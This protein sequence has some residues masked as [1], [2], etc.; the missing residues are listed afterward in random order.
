MSDFDPYE[1]LGVPRD[2]DA[3]ALR[4][5][6][7]KLARRHHPDLAPGD[8][9]AHE[10]FEQVQRAYWVL[11]DPERRG[12]FDAGRSGVV[13][14]AAREAGSSD[15]LRTGRIG[16][17][18]FLEIRAEWMEWIE[19]GPDSVR[20]E[21]PV[22]DLGAELTLDFAEAI[23]GVTSSFSVQRERPCERCGGL[24]VRRHEPCARCG[25]RGAV[26]E[27]DRLRVRIPPAVDDG[28]LLR[29]PGKGPF[30]RSGRSDRSGG[31]DEGRDAG[32]LLLT[33]RVRPHAYF[34]RDGLDIYAEVPVTFTEA[35]LGADID[36]PTI[37]GPASVRLPAGTQGGQRFRL[38]G[39]GIRRDG[40][41]VGDHFYTVRIV[42]PESLDREL[43]DLLRSRDEASPRRSLPDRAL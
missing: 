9:V 13:E 37:D 21:P 33:I 5:A 25:G 14:R 38:R 23:R 43:A 39:R 7:Q 35:A 17:E 8:R 11:S 29:L 20:P 28:T 1:I 24:G 4:R 6:Y 16:T 40:E 31:F 41:R 19:A 36:V 30:A 10:R 2:A 15:S 3:A 12:R 27:L 26:V 22:R 42:V 34:Q 18:S 32:D